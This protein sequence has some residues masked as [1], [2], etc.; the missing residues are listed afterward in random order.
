MILN[1]NSRGHGQELARHLLNVEDN[2]HAM[3]HEL[4]GFIGDDLMGAFAEVEA[5]AKG[6]KCQQYL[7]SL[8]L[9]P[10]QLEAVSIET[11]E[12]TIDTIEAKLGLSGQP[13][14]IVFHE[15]LGRRH[16]HCVWSRVDAEAM[17]GINLPYFKRKLTDI[18]RELYRTHGWHMPAG[19]VRSE[20]RDPFNYSHAQ[21]GQA[22]RVKRDPK[23][24]KAL[25]QRCW[26][27]SDSASAFS[28]ALAEHRVALARGDGRGFIAVDVDGEVY[29]LSRWCG[30]K[31][32]LLRAKLGSEDL[33]PT[34][35]EARASLTT[36]HVRPYVDTNLDQARADHRVRIKTLVTRQRDERR[37]LVASQE[38]RKAQEIKEARRSLPTGLAA[39]WARLTGQHKKL[40]DALNALAMSRNAR[41]LRETEALISR[42]LAERRELN[43]QHAFIE[44]LHALTAEAVEWQ[45][46]SQSRY[47]PDPRQPLVLP[48][49][50]P[51]FSVAQLKRDPTLIINQLSQKKASFTRHDIARS[52]SEFIDDP[53]DLR[54]AIDRAMLSSELVP[55]VS[56]GKPT[57]TTRS[58][59]AVEKDLAKT[60]TA[61]ER[62]GGFGVAS[63]CIN[64]SIRKQNQYLQ[65]AV[66]SRLTEEQTAAI[67]HVL[68]PNQLSNVVGLAGTGKS[69]LL[70]VARDAW[71]RQGYTVHGAALAGKAADGLESASGIPSRTLASLEK[72]WE[73]GTEPIACGDVVVID[74]AG[75]VGTRQLNR[76]LNRLN[77]LGCKVVL[78]GDPDQLQPIQAG[79]PFRDLTETC[80]AARLTEIRRQKQEWQRQ[81]SK[82]LADG[83]LDAALQAYADE[84]AVHEHETTDEAITA[85]VKDFLSDVEAHGPHR[86]RLALAHRRK[87]VYAINQAIRQARK[88]TEDSK[89]ELL[90]P[91]DNGPRAFA[92]GD[93]IL[94]ARN[95]R[96]LGVRNG[97]LGTVTSVT[98]G[99][100][101]VQLDSE[102]KTEARVLTVAPD[103]YAHLDHGYAVTIHRAQG[104][105]VDRS[106]VLSSP[107][108][109]DQL[110][111]VAMTRHRDT[112]SLYGTEDTL[113]LSRRDGL[114]RFI[115]AARSPFKAPR[116]TP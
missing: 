53:L 108:M 57:F 41:D 114:Q 22:K 110:A 88:E 73:N 47:A 2:E 40:V 5:I 68:T 20:D 1:G 61:M 83:Y 99:K 91:T 45:T 42:H 16:A 39:A 50:I 27:A 109:N 111:Y 28:A 54:V 78:V 24:L 84:N 113:S 79:E 98:D 67:K 63:G 55:L 81:A 43:H 97:M 104:C 100:L 56:D 62:L 7:F 25:F 29:S 107:T 101:K 102:G 80:G 34:V 60:A 74:E 8:S 90:V 106:F 58:F 96:T 17:K 75:M 89:E 14:A 105:T 23:E 52:L 70:S 86:S 94:F 95:D 3:V 103:G 115:E 76:V 13:R 18:S 15:K 82:D 6:T 38:R 30:V 37:D 112:L 65:R 36:G 87:D 72:S 48:R 32:K 19:L 116:R 66:G 10:P 71:E 44:A 51:P 35:E 26:L 77:T 11:F 21:A 93:R 49:D 46:P 92:E 12:A 31:P 9:N 4:R 59:Q 64:A 33:L 85:L 69:T